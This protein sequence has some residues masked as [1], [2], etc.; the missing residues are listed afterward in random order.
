[1]SEHIVRLSYR[2]KYET[3]D[4][5]PL[6]EIID[7]LGSL[8]TLLSSTSAVLSELSHVDILG[9]QLY[10]QRIESGSLIEDIC[11]AL[12]F[13]NKEKMD[14]FLQ[15]L[16][17]S[18]MQPIIIGAILG[19]A[20]TFGYH[21]LTTNNTV[22]IE[23]SGSMI[24]NSPNSLIINFPQGTLDEDTKKLLNDEIGKRIRNKD[25]FAKQTMNFM[26]P[27]RRDPNA[28]ISFGEGSTKAELPA[29]SIKAVP[30]KYAAKKNNLFV[31]MSGVTVKLRATD[32]D[33]KKSGWAGSIEGITNRVKVELDPTIDPIEIYGK[34]S[35]TADVTLERSY[36]QQANQLVPKRIIIRSII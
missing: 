26:E 5:V 32:L 9:H 30:K 17:K 11:V 1:M 23:N 36:N 20:L 35:I 33:S 12:M 16:H 4:P 21:V 24:S 14:D 31:D 18:K 22:P 7:A 29:S 34:T 3:K 2:I 15:W 19:G 28:K 6:E 27:A 10:V 25:D 8:N 13:G